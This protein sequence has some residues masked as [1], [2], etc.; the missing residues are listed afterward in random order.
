MIER[1]YPGVYV[2]EMASGVRPIDGVPT[3]VES[4]ATEAAH[5]HVPD[6]ADHNTHDPGIT[7]MELLAYSIE[8]LQYRMNHIPNPQPRHLL[9]AL[10]ADTSGT[11]SIFPKT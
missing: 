5:P 2:T 8:S 3:A 4:A 7:L 11:P 10:R 9:D 6:W 1:V